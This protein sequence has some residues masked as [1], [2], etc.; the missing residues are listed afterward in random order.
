MLKFVLVIQ[1]CYAMQG[2][3]NLP[4]PSD[5]KYETHKICALE[6]YKKAGEL[7]GELDSDL[8]NKNRILFKFWCI[9]QKKE[10]DVKKEIST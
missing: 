1:M 2:V 10:D 7:I 8:V 9:E 4:M 6:G 3:C 5:V